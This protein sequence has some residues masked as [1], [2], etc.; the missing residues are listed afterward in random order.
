MSGTGC[1]F[2]S[3]VDE[4]AVTALRRR[5]REGERVTFVGGVVVVVV[6]VYVREGVLAA[7]KSTSPACE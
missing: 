1:A 5:Y 3:P 4:A 6:V 2:R 7:L